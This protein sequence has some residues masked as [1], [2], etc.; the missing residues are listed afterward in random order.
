MFAKV[1][2]IKNWEI[3]TKYHDN[4]YHQEPPVYSNGKIVYVPDLTKN[5]CIKGLYKKENVNFFIEDKRYPSI[6]I[7]VSDKI[8]YVIY[9]VKSPYAIVG[10]IVGGIF[11]GKCK[12]Y[13]SFD[14]KNWIKIWEKEKTEDTEHYENIDVIVNNPGGG[15]YQTADWNPSF[16]A[17]YSY[18]VKYEFLSRGAGLDKVVLST[19]IQ[20]APKSLPALKLGINNISFSM[21][22]N[23]DKNLLNA[24][25]KIKITYAW[26]EN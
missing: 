8:A 11:K 1:V 13:I 12:L 9:K 10:G 24:S 3:G 18:F 16:N 7:D 5:N 23:K 15:D 19:D 2:L 17:K 14:T 6:H 21:D 25:Q 20:I 26:E 22:N 4:C